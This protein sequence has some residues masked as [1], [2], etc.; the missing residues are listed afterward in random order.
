[1]PSKAR[2]SPAP[3]K[4]TSKSASK[5][6]SKSASK[7]ASKVGS[8]LIMKKKGV[9]QPRP[10]M[11]GASESIKASKEFIEAHAK[12]FNAAMIKAGAKPVVFYK[13]GSASLGK[14]PFCG[15]DK[16]GKIYYPV[17]HKGARG[18]FRFNCKGSGQT[19]KGDLAVAAR[20]GKKYP[21][22]QLRQMPAESLKK[23]YRRILGKT[24]NGLTKANMVDGIYEYTMAK[25]FGKK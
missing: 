8:G 20:Q 16:E 12:D 24:T 7:S 2:K 14:M 23:L 6:V 15:V 10:R 25:N 22:T 9:R 21:K 4:T 11:K 18:S 5:S 1:M 17:A 3:K 19:V 13:N